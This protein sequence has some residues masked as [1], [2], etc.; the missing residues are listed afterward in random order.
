MQLIGLH[1]R[2]NG[3]LTELIS[4]AT[5]FQLPFFQC[6]LTDGKSG[7]LFVPQDDDKRSF[8]KIRQNFKDLY[9]HGSYFINLACPKRRYHPLLEQEVRLAKQLE[10][11]H[12]I[13]HPGT[14]SDINEKGKGI[15]AVARALNFL[16]KRETGIQFLLENTAYGPNS[17]GS[18]INDFN[19]ILNKIDRPDRIGFCIDTVHAH[20]SGYDIISDNGHKEFLDLLQKSVGIQNIKL[21]HLNDTEQQ[22]ASH[23]DVHCC[24]GD[25][26]A[27]IGNAALKR[28]LHD[29]NY[30]NIP[31]LAELP[32]LSDEKI[33]KVLRE[34]S[35]WDFKNYGI[36]KGRR[37][38]A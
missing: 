20:V 17:I 32:E 24:I 15:D 27:C 13:I 35:D 28:F 37:L 8:F 34:V 4:K 12:M 2:L 10:F 23:L 7:K 22:C 5:T 14:I 38:C 11:T 3:S 36:K 26:N 25:G 21:I 33:E 19:L 31:K 30:Y 18:T 9:V 29:E 16:I 6:F 1:L